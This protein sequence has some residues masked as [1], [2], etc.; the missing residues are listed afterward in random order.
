LASIV[1]VPNP[2]KL[3]VASLTEQTDG[4]PEEKETGNPED[5]VAATA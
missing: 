5:A 1:H 4:V 2:R 3:T